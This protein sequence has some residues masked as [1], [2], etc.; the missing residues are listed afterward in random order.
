MHPTKGT[1]IGKR[2]IQLVYA[3]F[4]P[5]AAPKAVVVIVHGYGEHMGRYKHVV[6]A[7]VQHEYAVYTLDHRGH[8]ESQGVRAHVEHFGYFVDD[9]HL[10][11]QKA[12]AAYPDLPL[13]M[14]AHSMGGLIAIHYALRHQTELAGLVATG[15][16]LVIGDDVSPLLKR[17][18]GIV[19]RVA[20]T[21]AVT[22]ATKSP[23]SV[24]SR[25]PAVQ[26]LFDSDPLCYSG[27]VRARMGYEM[28]SA[29]IGARARLSE[30]R[31]PL[32][33]MYGAEDTLTN[34]EGAKQLYA[35]AASADKTIKPWPGCRHEIFNEPEKAEVLAFM[36]QWLDARVV[37][38]ARRPADLASA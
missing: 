27:K 1:L 5:D 8:G 12:R 7:L 21:L 34:P 28:M 11:V 22:P 15:P 24:L 30:I 33:V 20:P 3:T 13:F 38:A 17:V 31:L 2:S 23:E 36:L 32:L 6:E 19:A 10:L 9:L 14:V 18:S 4:V 35:Q 26:E 37:Q 29:G 16:A 25:D